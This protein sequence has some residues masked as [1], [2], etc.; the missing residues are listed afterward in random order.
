V[1]GSVS[2]PRGAVPGTDIPP[3]PLRPMLLDCLARQASGCRAARVV[4][5][6]SEMELVSAGPHRL[7]VPMPGRAERLSA[8][9]RGTAAC[10]PVDDREN[11]HKL[12]SDAASSSDLQLRARWSPGLRLTTAS[13]VKPRQTSVPHRQDG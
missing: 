9:R 1:P 13:P 4:C 2:W 3:L 6:Q 5:V 12:G 7:C 10:E 8:P 11:R